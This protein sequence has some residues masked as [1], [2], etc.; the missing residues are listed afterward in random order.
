MTAS[1]DNIDKS[2]MALNEA[3]DFQQALTAYDGAAPSVRPFDSARLGGALR[4]LSGGRSLG[5]HIV[6]PASKPAIEKMTREVPGS[7]SRYS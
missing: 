3:G 1:A 2:A 7:R 5:G 6:G 4:A